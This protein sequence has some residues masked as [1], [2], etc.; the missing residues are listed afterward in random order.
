[1][2]I[3]FNDA[4]AELKTLTKDG[5]KATPQKLRNLAASVSVNSPGSVNHA[6]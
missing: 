6:C 1:M 2:S 3:T 4:L 5:R